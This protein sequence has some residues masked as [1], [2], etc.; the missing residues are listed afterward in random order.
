MLVKQRRHV[1]GTRTMSDG[2]ACRDD[3]GTSLMDE[4]AEDRRRECKPEVWVSGRQ[5]AA[6]PASGLAFCTVEAEREWQR[7]HI[8]RSSDAS[9]TSCPSAPRRR[10]ERK[11]AFDLRDALWRSR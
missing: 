2:G 1:C 9:S 11:V 7:L 6:R 10:E 4:K 3:R 5:Q 8:L